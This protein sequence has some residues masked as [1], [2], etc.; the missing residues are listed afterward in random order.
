MSDVEVTYKEPLSRKEAARYL[1]AL[2][3]ALQDEGKVELDLGATRMTVHVPPQ[4]R[5]KVEI[6]TDEDEIELEVELTWSPARADPVPTPQDPPEEADAAAADE[7][8][9]PARSPA[10][11]KAGSK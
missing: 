3:A 2:A 11:R 4:V 5:C 9:E 10:R 1:S 6:E 8:T 7:D